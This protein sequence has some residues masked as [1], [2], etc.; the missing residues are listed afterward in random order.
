MLNIFI[1]FDKWTNYISLL[2]VLAEQRQEVEHQSVDKMA[3]LEHQVN[4]AKREHAK[5][6]LYIWI[7]N[8]SW[9]FY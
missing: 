1:L 6:G 3:D 4:D 7:Y 8:T 9:M 5:T 2:V